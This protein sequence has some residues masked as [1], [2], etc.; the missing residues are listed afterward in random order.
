MAPPTCRSEIL[1]HLRRQIEDGKP[2]VGAG[3]GKYFVSPAS[4]GSRLSIN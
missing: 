2:I 3:A 4:R 1:A